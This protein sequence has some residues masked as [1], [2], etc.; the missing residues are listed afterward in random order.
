MFNM[1]P[2]TQYDIANGILQNQVQGHYLLI[3]FEKYG[4][5]H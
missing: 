3:T 4:M 5:N 1:T 2:F